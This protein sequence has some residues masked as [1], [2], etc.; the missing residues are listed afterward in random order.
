MSRPEWLVCASCFYYAD[1]DVC[2]FDP[3]AIDTMPESFCSKWTCAA[4]GGEYYGD[5]ETSH[6]DCMVVVIELEE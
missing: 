1:P 2:L 3:G 5:E 6:A 4:C